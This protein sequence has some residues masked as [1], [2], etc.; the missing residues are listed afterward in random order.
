MPTGTVRTRPGT[1]REGNGP[2]DVIY[3]GQCRL[4]RR[5]LNLFQRLAGRDVFRFHDAN[6]GEMIRSKFPRLAHADTEDAMFVVTRRGEVFRG[7]FAF[8]RMVWESPRLYP[9]L[10][11]FYAPGAALIG[12]RIYAWVA[13]NRR[14]LGCSLSDGPSCGDGGR[15]GPAGRAGKPPERLAAS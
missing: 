11:L 10:V 1:T 6:Q 3:D 14:N 8:R 13:R 4:C 5:S 7:F 9:L 15:G 12:P 2:L